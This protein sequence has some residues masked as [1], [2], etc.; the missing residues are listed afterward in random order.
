MTLSGRCTA[1]ARLQDLMGRTQIIVGCSKPPRPWP[2]NLGIS[3]PTS[4]TYHDSAHLLSVAAAARAMAAPFWLSRAQQSPLAE[5]SLRNCWTRWHKTNGQLSAID[6][7]STPS[8]PHVRVADVHDYRNLIQRS[9][10]PDTP[11]R[12]PFHLCATEILASETALW[13]IPL[14]SQERTYHKVRVS[15][16]TP[17]CW[18]IWCPTTQSRSRKPARKC[19]RTTRCHTIVSSVGRQK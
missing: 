2:W 12:R 4:T 6:A 13:V 14:S 16:N 7:L 19:P 10:K 3:S 8:A 9:M 5:R 17:P 15:P 11:H 1:Q 18:W